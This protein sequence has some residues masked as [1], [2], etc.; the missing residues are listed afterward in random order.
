MFNT[1]NPT[2]GDTYTYRVIYSDRTTQD[3]SASVAS[4]LNTSN[5]AQNLVAQTTTPGTVTVPLFTWAAPT[6]IAAS[7]TYRLK[8]N[9]TNNSTNWNYPQNNGLPSTTTPLQVLYN[10]DNSAS[11]PLVS[12]VGNTYNWQV[13]V[14]DSNGNSAT[15]TATYAP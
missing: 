9:G 12:G 5:M 2:V 3:L 14:R 11:G 4:V 10:V 15:N 6:S 13:Q 1:V 7:S 8:L